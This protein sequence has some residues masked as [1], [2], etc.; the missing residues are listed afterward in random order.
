MTKS[1]V[2]RAAAAV[3]FAAPAIGPSLAA[4]L[5]VKAPVV[6][7]VYS[8]TGFYVGGNVGGAWQHASFNS[9]LIGC[10]IVGCASGLP[11][12]GFDPAIAA[13]G[14]GSST[15]AGFTG[16]GQIG[17]NWQVNTLVL[18]VEADINAL[19]GKPALG[20]TTGTVT[21]PS[22]GTFTIATSAGADWLATVRGR[23]G[24]AADRFLVYATGGAAFAHIKF[25]HSF[26][27]LCCTS[28][29]PLTTFTTSSTKAG[30]AVGGG[31]EYAIAANWSLRGE[32]LYAGGF[33]SVGGS[34]VATSANGNGDRHTGSAKLSI[35]Q[36][37]AALN[38]KFN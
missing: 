19:S 36:A 3:L 13:A 30:Y 15:K 31:A 9:T 20:P 37:R 8:W 5:P 14:T 17:Y 7:A 32:Y 11:H 2:I 1:W 12:I 23:L 26:S 18:G 35:H 28:S 34:Y 33:S 6:V 10:N 27:D 21:P 4:D 22:T 25:R 38:F 29:T 24:F 16:G